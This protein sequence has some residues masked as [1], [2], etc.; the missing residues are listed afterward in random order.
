[1]GCAL[2]I[3]S[4]Q[5]SLLSLTKSDGTTTVIAGGGSTY[6]LTVANLGSAPTTGLITVVDVLPTGLS[7]AGN[8]PF[9]SG[10]FAC[11]LAA[12]SRSISCVTSTSLAAGANAV[13]GIPLTVD[14][15]APSAV[16]NRAQ[17][18]GGGDPSK[19]LAPTEAT[20]SLCSA[21]ASD[22]ATGCAADTNIVKRVALSLTKDDG[23]FNVNING[24][25]TYAFTVTNSGDAA[26]IGSIQ[27]RDVLPAPM[28]WPVT[29]VKS[30]ANAADWTCVRA[31]GTEVTCT[32]NVSIPG[33]ASSQFSLLANAGALTSA[34]QYTNKARIGGGGDPNLPLTTPDAGSVALC[35]NNNVPAGCAIDMNTAQNA[36]QIRLAKT[37]ANPQSRGPGDTVAFTLT[38][39]NTGGNAAA[40]NTIRV[41]DV[42]PAGFSAPVVNP[43]TQG[44][45]SCSV[46]A[47]VLTCNNTGG[48]LAANANAVITFNA[49]VA[50]GATN[51]LTNAAQVGTA[52][53][54]TDPQNST[55]PTDV[56]AQ[57]CTA[58]GVPFVGCA[59][60]SV[61][62]NADLQ[63]TKEQKLS[64]A[65]AY[66]TGTLVASNG[67]LVQFR[68]KLT[69]AGPSVVSNAKLSDQIPSNFTSPTIVSVT[70]AG[71]VTGCS[72]TSVTL[73]GNNLTGT[74][75]SMAKDASCTVIVQATASTN[76]ASITNTATAVAPDGINDSVPANNS[77][78]VVTTIQQPGITATK[79]ASA[80][81]LLVGAAGQNYKIA[82]TV[83][84]GPTTA[85]ISVADT[86]PTGIT[87]AGVPTVNNGATLSGCTASSG[88]ALGPNCQLNSGLANGTYTVTIPVAVAASAVAAGGLNKANIGGGGDPSCTA[89]NSNETCDPST[90]VT[91]V[92]Q[93]ADLSITKTAS[94]A[95]SYVPGQ[96]LN[97]T[98][99]VS[100]AGPS[101]VTGVSVADTVP[102]S[103][104]VTSWSCTASA[105]ATCGTAGGTTNTVSLP[106]ASLASGSSITIS[107]TGKAQL[108]ATGDI[109]N[110]ATVTPPAGVS[111]TTAPCVRTATVTNTNGGTPGLAITK[112]ATP[113]AFAVGQTGIYSLSVRNNGTSSTSGQITVTDAMPTGITI[114]PALTNNVN[115]WDCSASTAS[116]L[117]CTN[118]VVLLPGSNAPVINAPVSIANGTASPVT[119]TAS[120]SGGGTACTAATCQSELVTNVN[121]PHLDVTKSLNG[122]FV[123][124][125]P[126]SYVITATNNGQAATLAGTITDVIPAGLVIG[127]LPA[128]CSA[129]AQTLTCSVPSGLSTG[130]SVS[131]TIPVTPSASA[132][133][134]ALQN[135]AKA[136]ADTGDASCPAAAHCSGT[137]DNS[138]TAPQLT[139]TKNASVATFTVGQAAQ[140]QLVLRNTGTAATTAATTVTDTVPAGLTIDTA[141]LPAGC[142]NTPAGSQTLVCTVA[143]LAVNA[144]VAL[145]ITVTPQNT[146]NGISVTNQATA[147]GGGDP[148]CANGTQA[149]SLPARCAPTNTTAVNAPRLVLSKA[150]STPTFSVGVPASYTL[151]VTNTGTAA[152]SGAI[153]ITDVMPASLMLGTL[154]AGCTAQGQQ[155]SCTITQSLTASPAAGSEASFV[156]P[157]T[158]IASAAPSVTNTA[159]ALGAVIRPARQRTTARP[160]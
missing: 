85:T 146:V 35:T 12:N 86:L 126:T 80:T 42:L 55:F 135:V 100:N 44:I 154:P 58:N 92:V 2:D 123:V 122:S 38:V 118:S 131:F 29:L 72:A 47:N 1:M 97:Y 41:V 119:N 67:A 115:G 48:V 160:A 23:Q 5:S 128:S 27:F 108:A 130:S 59:T 6:A 40:V 4:V 105:G 21:A 147:T 127:T 17:I 31:S 149:A 52:S 25:T 84:S 111:C 3:D 22:L 120:V 7:F 152:T 96:D 155:V 30:G 26:S 150:A 88:S 99:V 110:T 93:K 112:V 90:P 60:D 145:N 137:T 140:Y 36:A 89:A 10:G 62:L 63:I 77:A 91:T 24:T 28:N 82:I 8:S 57:T 156:I 71:T 106:G 87:L 151:S 9:N 138:V 65:A 46:A 83:S 132:N 64:T 33:G 158:P 37:H 20:A 98:L 34:E 49:T 15:T 144:S 141:A 107:I 153:T 73:D 16:T 53:S 70:P 81:P 13:I 18:G 136:N 75:A 125:Q 14:S 129:S 102:A 142:T 116:Q 159:T 32:S 94:P 39:S 101:D 113:S 56:T 50:T 43:A 68:L 69:N 121:A 76:G 148:L 11:T 61:P 124:G 95:S 104:A 51:S 54:S 103:V 45:F 139:L 117:S 157:V 133:N 66:Q 79:T 19:P 143:S 109:V 78:S 134:Q 74:L 114:T